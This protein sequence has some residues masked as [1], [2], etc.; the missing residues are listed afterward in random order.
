[1]EGFKNEYQNK[2][3]W[4]NQWIDLIINIKGSIMSGCCCVHWWYHLC[5]QYGHLSFLYEQWIFDPIENS[6]KISTVNKLKFITA[7]LCENKL[8]FIILEILIGIITNTITIQ[9]RK[10]NR[11]PFD[12][13]YFDFQYNF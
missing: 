13:F 5:N 11:S 7:K 9:W 12:R 8:I 2:L 10:K 1:M 6:N 4:F 3:H